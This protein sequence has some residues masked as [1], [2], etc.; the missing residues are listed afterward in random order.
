MLD[1]SGHKPLACGHLREVYQHPRQADTL[2]KLMRADIVAKRWNGAM[3]WYK[4]LPRTRHYSGFVRELKESIAFQARFPNAVPPIA[5]ALGLV[6]TS[7][8]LGLLVEKVSAFDRLAPTLRAYL[9]EHGF[10][11]KIEAEVEAFFEGLL[12]CD[13]I[14]GD[15]HSRNIVYG[16]D[17]HGGPRLVMIDGYG[18]KN[19]IPRC[20]M[21]K[22]MNR[23][24]TLRHRKRL[25]AQLRQYPSDGN[26]DKA[27]I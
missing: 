8:G 13:V 21:S 22:R 14:V 25:L 23:W 12:R 19:I 17:S 6:E 3:R 7:L 5:K 9:E 11:P 24:N 4:R 16:H 27:E 2:I 18:E 1:L 10:T 26:L 20:S 15:I